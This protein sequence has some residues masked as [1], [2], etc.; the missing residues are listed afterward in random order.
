MLKPAD[1]RNELARSVPALAADPDKL[2]VFID[3]GRIEASG[4]RALAFVY[5]YTLNLIVTDWA[6]DIDML[7]VP[8][9]AWLKKHQPEIFGNPDT[10]RDGFSFEAEIL[11]N[12]KIDISIKLKLS[13]RVTSRDLGDGRL[14]VTHHLEPDFLTYPGIETWELYIKGEKVG[15]WQN[16]I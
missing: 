12:D 7:T 16:Q 14:E 5:R 2:H 6:D 9:L 15:E 4:T 11:D 3:S 1:L 13:E 10:W 8:I